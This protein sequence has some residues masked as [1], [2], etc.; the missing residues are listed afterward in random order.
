MPRIRKPFF[1]PSR[2]S[3]GLLP[4]NDG[5]AVRRLPFT[6]VKCSET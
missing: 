5:E 2:T 3:A 1:G 6:T 4:K